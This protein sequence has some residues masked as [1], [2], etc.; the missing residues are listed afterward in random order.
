[1][2]NLPVVLHIHYK[3][4][5]ILVYDECSRF[6]SK[7]DRLGANR[8][9]LNRKPFVFMNAISQYELIALHRNISVQLHL[10]NTVKYFLG[11]MYTL[12]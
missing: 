10:N 7:A 3:L 5:M 12:K 11:R 1:M 4:N 8:M 6:V 9:S 2:T